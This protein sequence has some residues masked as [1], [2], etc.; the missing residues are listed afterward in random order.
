MV[1]YDFKV[2]ISKLW[3]IKLVELKHIEYKWNE[4]INLE[5]YLKS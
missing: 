1:E 4:I 2:I 3:L 5:H